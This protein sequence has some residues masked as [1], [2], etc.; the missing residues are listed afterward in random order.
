MENTRS[1]R[2]TFTIWLL[3]TLVIIG[4]IAGNMFVGLF[5]S[6][7][8]ENISSALEDNSKKNALDV[9]NYFELRKTLLSLAA[10]R[11][12]LALLEGVNE[13]FY[14]NSPLD[15]NENFTIGYSQQ[16]LDLLD[17]IPVRA[18]D[19]PIDLNLSVQFE[20][21]S[22]RIRRYKVIY[23]DIVW[24]FLA[25]ERTQDL[26]ADVYQVESS[27]LAN[28]QDWYRKI[29]SERKLLC[30]LLTMMKAPISF[31][32]LWRGLY[33]KM[34]SKIQPHFLGLMR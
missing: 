20:D 15:T 28:R 9:Q 17:S 14:F 5:R 6:V 24:M 23:P 29:K 11:N 18:P 1:L 2:W 8:E 30:F 3:A 33:L 7:V 31:C 32:L 12:I 4:A 21:F 16:D 22:R 25:N 13:R 34:K 10:R 19:S 27:Y 26:L